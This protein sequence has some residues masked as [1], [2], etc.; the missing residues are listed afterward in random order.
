MGRKWRPWR[1][2]CKE[3]HIKTKDALEQ[4][5]GVSSLSHP[6]LTHLGSLRRSRQEEHPGGR[7]YQKLEPQ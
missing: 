6:P 1:E 5:F 3:A 2:G 7:Q 4:N